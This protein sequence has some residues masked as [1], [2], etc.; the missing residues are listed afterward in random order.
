ME[1]TLSQTP[2]HI[3][4]SGLLFTDLCTGLIVQPVNVATILPYTVN[5]KQAINRPLLNVTFKTIADASA[6]YFMAIVLLLLTLMSVERWRHMSRRSLIAP[7]RGCAIALMVVLIPFPMA[8]FR[9][10]QT[11]NPGSI[12]SAYNATVIAVI[13]ICFLT[14]FIA[15][16][17]VIRIIRSHQLHVKANVAS[18]HFGQTAINSSSPSKYNLIDDSFVFF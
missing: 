10:L 6:T 3:L 18:Q 2:F 15:Y 5:E 12:G 4:L 17:N 13:L 9:S 1:K 16:F 14:T 8:V 7:R 11:I